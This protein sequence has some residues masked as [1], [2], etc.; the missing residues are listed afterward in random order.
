MIPARHSRP[1]SLLGDGPNLKTMPQLRPPPVYYTSPRKECYNRPPGQQPACHSVEK[2]RSAMSHLS[3]ATQKAITNIR[4]YLAGHL[5]EGPPNTFT[6]FTFIALNGVS[7]AMIL[8]GLF[9][10][11]AG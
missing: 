8:E 2:A 3:P 5:P 6:S 11:P 1:N 4:E 7:D 10:P 9:Q